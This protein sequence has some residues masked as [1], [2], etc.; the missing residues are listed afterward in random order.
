MKE[1]KIVTER[2]QDDYIAYVDGEPQICGCSITRVLA[3]YS[4]IKSHQDYFD[5][6]IKCRGYNEMGI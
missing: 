3:V 5:V 1:H 4:M 2:K 6:D